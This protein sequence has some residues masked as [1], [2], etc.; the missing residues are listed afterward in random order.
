MRRSMNWRPNQTASMTSPSSSASRATVR[1]RRRG[2]I[3]ATLERDQLEPGRDDGA[4]LELPGSRRTERWPPVAI[5]RRGTVNSRSRTVAMPSRPPDR[6][7]AAAPGRPLLP[8]RWSKGSDG[9]A[10]ARIGG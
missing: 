4:P 2:P 10:V 6:R 9:V 5:Q 3:G 1:C 7:S 8:M